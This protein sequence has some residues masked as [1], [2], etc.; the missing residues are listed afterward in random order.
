MPPSYP[1][2]PKDDKFGRAYLDAD[3]RS[4]ISSE[5]EESREARHANERIQ[6]RYS[7][8]GV[9]P[10]PPRMVEIA[11]DGASDFSDSQSGNNSGHHPCANAPKPKSTGSYVRLPP[12]SSLRYGRS[13]PL[14]RDVVR[15]REIH[16][17][18]WMKDDDSATGDY[19]RDRHLGLGEHSRYAS[20]AKISPSQRHEERF[21]RRSS[22]SSSSS[23]L[24]SRHSRDGPSDKDSSGSFSGDTLCGDST[25]EFSYGS[26]GSDSDGLRGRS[27]A[28]RR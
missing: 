23:F 13:S 21:T 27:P 26:Q 2:G 7:H 14:R 10:R 4:E 24:S 6:R 16:L 28:R 22:N 17:P 1:Q 12:P 5:S 11:P 20:S 18:S 3:L 8:G 15:P 19:G 25:S 9:S